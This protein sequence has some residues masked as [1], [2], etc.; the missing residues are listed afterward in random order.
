MAGIDLETQRHA[1]MPGLCVDC[2]TFDFSNASQT[3]EVPTHLTRVMFG[4]AVA[5]LTAT[6]DP[7]QTTLAYKVGDASNGAVTFIRA[8]GN[9]NED[10]RMSFIVGGY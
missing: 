6:D 8:G 9:N 2:G 10:A 1:K 4:F 5:D 3:A 7:Q